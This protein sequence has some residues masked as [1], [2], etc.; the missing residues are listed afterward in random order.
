MFKERMCPKI[1]YLDLI[2]LGGYILF[3]I[4]NFYLFYAQS[5]SLNNAYP[6]DL[7]A[8]ISAGLGM[9]TNYSLI[10]VLEGWLVKSIGNTIIS[11]FVR[12]IYLP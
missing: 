5:L 8:H 12:A 6:S 10:S 11:N 4:L 9:Y 2:V 3:F 1:K 7:G